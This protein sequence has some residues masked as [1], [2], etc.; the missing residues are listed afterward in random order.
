MGDLKFECWMREREN[1]W[2]IHSF[3]PLAALNAIFEIEKDS[4]AM[5]KTAE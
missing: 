3:S 1:D 2:R 4:R 5:E